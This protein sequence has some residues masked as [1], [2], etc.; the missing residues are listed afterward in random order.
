MIEVWIYDDNLSLCLDR[1]LL[2]D[3]SRWRDINWEDFINDVELKR[4]LK[5]NKLSRDTYRKG[6]RINTEWFKPL[7]KLHG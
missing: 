6:W 4:I 7:W 2:L 1:R 5:K 3:V